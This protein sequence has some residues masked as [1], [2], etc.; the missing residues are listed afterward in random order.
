[1]AVELFI[2]ML[3]FVSAGLI[4]KACSLGLVHFIGEI[5]SVSFHKFWSTD[6]PDLMR[7]GSSQVVSEQ[8]F[9]DLR[10]QP[11]SCISCRCLGDFR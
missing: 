4:C 2:C 6:G 1:M 8:R 10:L 5:L 7:P 11:E 3:C 9:C